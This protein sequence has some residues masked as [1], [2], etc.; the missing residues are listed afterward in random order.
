VGH[1]QGTAGRALTVG[2]MFMSAGSG[3]KKKIGIRVD[4]QKIVRKLFDYRCLWPSSGVGSRACGRATQSE[5]LEYPSESIA[6]S[7]PRSA[8]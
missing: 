6:K 8:S 3:V 4:L 7:S 1:P 2:R 5:S